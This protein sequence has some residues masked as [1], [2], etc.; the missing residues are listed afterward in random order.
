MNEIEKIRRELAKAKKEL[1]EASSR[2]RKYH[3]I[4]TL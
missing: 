3:A 2:T 1:K 4:V